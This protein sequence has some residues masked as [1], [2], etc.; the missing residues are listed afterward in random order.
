MTVNRKFGYILLA[1]T[2]L[3]HVYG[4]AAERKS[5]TV[6]TPGTLNSLISGSE[7]Y[8]ITDLKISGRL[9]ADD[10]ALLRDMAGCN[11][12][13]EY[14]K[15][16]LR[17]LDMTAATL[18]PGET[19]YIGNGKNR[20]I[21]D[22]N[23]IPAYMFSNCRIERIE[24]PQN[25]KRIGDMAFMQSALKKIKLPENI[26]LESGAFR[27]CRNLSDVTF[28]KFTKEIGVECFSGCSKLKKISIND[29]GYIAFHAFT[30]IENVTE[31]TIHGVLGHADGWMCY[32]MP[33]LK[34]LRFE[35]FI[36]STGGP[37]IAENCPDLE[38][39][40]FLG[41][42]VSMGFGKVT[43]CPLTDK[44]TVKGYIIRS[45][46]RD[47]IE[48][49]EPIVQNAKFNEVCATLDRLTDMPQYSEVFGVEYALYDM[50]CVYSITGEKEKAVAALEKAIRK[51]YGNYK[52]L[53]QDKDLDNIRNEEGFKKL[54]EELRK[55]KDY[56]YVLKH[57]G[58][59]AT[60]Y[61]TNK[62]KFTYASPDD[63][64]MRKIR[65]FFNLDVIAGK[66]DE[67]SQMKNIMYWLHDQ[68]RH[69][70]SGGF[71]RNTK[72]NAID[73]Y[74]ACKAQ[75]RGL[76]CRG[77][78]I[79]LSEM[80]LAM[81]WQARFITCQPKDYI[82]DNDCHV[83]VMVW[84]RT[85][86]KWIWMDPSFA[87][88]V[89]DE[90]GLLL[91]PGEV[92]RRLIEGKPLVL[93]KDANWNHQSIQTKEYYLDEYMAKNL[94]YLSTYLH[95]GSNVESGNSS[96][97]F[98]LKPEGSDAEIGKDTYDESWFWQKP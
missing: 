21:T 11:K 90:N 2:L 26:I 7:K 93:N 4:M 98:T 9:N 33:S 89:C 80:Y 15:G 40:I 32:D 68:I 34:T 61:T 28:P 66:G 54:A 25:T 46:N 13:E 77:L 23:S 96:T 53:C 37:D 10:L 86:D 87:A 5:V 42:C 83:I 50:A 64:D 51:G 18:V 73:L 20:K 79:V 75:N 44:C 29:I 38:E 43:G 27:E 56:L 31:I 84:S 57:S 81:G 16:Q 59:Y 17:H 55:T 69:D 94:Y 74:N 52:W 49:E 88:Y 47:F 12:E 63:E 70:G 48:Y 91:H 65:T 97:Y 22:K 30:Q 78:A 14:T 62:E 85:L 1:V 71:P 8:E 58:P 36:I 39:I 41:D 76:N 72:R 60:A 19:T 45:A 6:K 35:D 95:N 24:L 67:I 82:H 3:L 92:R